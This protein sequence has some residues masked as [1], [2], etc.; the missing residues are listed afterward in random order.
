MTQ[1]KEL[2]VDTFVEVGT[3]KV[4][5]GMIRRIDKE[6]AGMSVQSADDIDA[7]LSSL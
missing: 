2:G 6:L 7:F 4:L 5:S 3:G 1:M